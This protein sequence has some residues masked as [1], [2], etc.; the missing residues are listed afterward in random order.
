MSVAKLYMVRKLFLK[1][2]THTGLNDDIEWEN[3][4]VKNITYI[5]ARCAGTSWLMLEAL[6]LVLLLLSIKCVK[7]AYSMDVPG[8]WDILGSCQ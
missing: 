8:G 5:L 4:C 1:S 7:Q 3:N 2:T 6:T